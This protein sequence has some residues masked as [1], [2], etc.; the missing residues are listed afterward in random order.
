MS[1]LNKK[2]PKVSDISWMNSSRGGRTDTITMPLG[3][4]VPSGVSYFGWK[5]SSYAYSYQVQYQ[6]I[7]RL[8][9]T[10]QLSTGTTTSSTA[11]KYPNKA[12]SGNVDTMNKSVAAD[13]KNRWYRYFNVAGL[14][15]MTKG[16]YD[17]LQVKVRV[18]SFNSK[19]TKK[20]GK[21]TYSYNH[22]NW[23]TK[24]L[25]IKCVPTVSIVKIIALADGGFNIYLNPGKWMRGGSKV[26]LNDVRHSGSSVI[27]NKR[28]LTDAVDAIGDPEEGAE[29]AQGVNYPCVT[30]G[31]SE[32]KGVKCPR[33]WM[34]STAANA[35]GLC[36]RCAAVVAKLDLDL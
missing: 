9:P 13:K 2:L 12:W 21:T 29:T 10:K 17:Q 16:S 15:F 14:S 3:G 36:P 11:W 26:I 24:T 4:V 34:H 35:E 1:T 6:V 22:G 33:C 7:A 23:Y 28:Q 30:V 25:T 8:T 31:V 18:R 20:K 5:Q 19:K 32:A 27:E